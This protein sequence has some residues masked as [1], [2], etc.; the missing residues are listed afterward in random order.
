[1]SK[2]A[3]PTLIGAFVVGAIA[4]V[5]IGLLVFGGGRFFAD[6]VTWVSYFPGSVKGLR[7][8]APVNFRGV[9]IGEVT[10]IQVL[11]DARDGSMLIPVVMEVVAGQVT[12]IDQ[13]RTRQREGADV[14]GLIARGLRAQLQT[15]SLVT[16]LLSVDLD[17][18]PDTP[19]QQIRIE[20]AELRNYPVVPAIPSRM[21]ELEQ[22]LDAVMREVPGLLRDVRG[23]LAEVTSG[24]TAANVDRILADVAHF[25]DSL[26]RATPAIERMV[27][28]TEQSVAAIQ[29]VAQS[30][31]G[32]LTGNQAAINGALGELQGTVAAVRRMADQVNNMVAENRQGLRDFTENGLYEIT[33]LAQDAQRMVDQITRLSEQLERD[34][35][36]FFFGDR[37]QGVRAQ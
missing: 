28:Q 31:D 20:S 29:H 27:E 10:G 25:T 37:G 35:A 4:L 11:Y 30:A 6:R 33:G 12:V 13:D 2:Q 7:V 34:P 3:S 1:M 36:R 19:E 23:L 16:G 15:D 24:N 22:S 5:V 26:D 21:A 9:R 17:F 8:G 14:E 18:Y 32:I